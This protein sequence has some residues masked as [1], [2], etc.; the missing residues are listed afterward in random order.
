MTYNDI[1]MI[2]TAKSADYLGNVGIKAHDPAT[3]SILA[4]T[5][6]LPKDKL[7]ESLKKLDLSKMRDIERQSFK[8]G[9][10]IRK[11]ANPLVGMGHA[12]P[13]EWS[14]VDDMVRR[15]APHWL[16]LIEELA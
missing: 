3:I 8:I 5:F 16:E 1:I 14:L 15:F 13:A 10:D 2:K 4:Q 6:E 12:E 9:H 7:S 11:D